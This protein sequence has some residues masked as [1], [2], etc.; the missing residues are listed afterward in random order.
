ML[1]RPAG[2]SA[3][4]M[5]GELVCMLCARTAADVEG[6]RDRRLGA[7]V[8]RPRALQHAESVRRL[9]CPHC[10]GRLWFRPSGDVLVDQHPLAEED[11]HSPCGRPRSPD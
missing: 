9:R 4:Q 1:D 10:A 7:N 6:P 2:P 5:Q 8:L 3:W 11:L